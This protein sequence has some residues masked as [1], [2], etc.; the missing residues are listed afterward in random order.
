[1][2]RE[3][4]NRPQV[5][6]RDGLK[7]FCCEAESRF[8]MVVMARNAEEAE[9]VALEFANDEHENYARRERFS[10]EMMQPVKDRKTI[11]SDWANSNPYYMKDVKEDETVGEIIEK[12]E[13]RQRGQ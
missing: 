12:W 3:P 8:A 5:E 10:I 7:M 2:K 11:P 9:E 6:D 1:M 4:D 13:E